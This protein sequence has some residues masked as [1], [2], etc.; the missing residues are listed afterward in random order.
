MSA[1]AAVAAAAPP[2]AAPRNLALTAFV[3]FV[4]LT[5]GF[6]AWML[7]RQYMN[8]G[9]LWTWSTVLT[10]LDAEQGGFNRFVL[11]YPQAQYYVLT[12][13]ALVPGAKSLL[14]P[15]AVAALVAAALL[16]HFTLGLLRAGLPLARALPIVALVAL[17]PALIWAV[18]NG[19]AEIYGIVLYYVLA[20]AIVGMRY[21]H[22]LRA[23]LVLA[24]VLLGFFLTDARS[25]YLALAL[26]PVLPLAL[27]PHL[28]RRGY[29]SPLAIIYTPLLCMIGIWLALNWVYTRDPL[30]FLQDP[31]SPFLGAR[32][33]LEH[34]PWRATF[35]GGVGGPL[36]AAVALMALCFPLLLAA[37]VRTR[38]HSRLFEAIAVLV[39]TPVI[40]TALA[41]AAEFT[42]SPADILVFVLGGVM[43]LLT[44]GLLHYLRHGLV[45][46]LLVAGNLGSLALFAWYPAAGMASWTAALAGRIERPALAG[47]L[48]LGIWAQ[49]AAPIMLDEA[50]GY[51]VIAAR[52][53]ATQLDLTFTNGFKAGVNSG[54]PKSRF[55]AVPDPATQ[56]GRADQLNRRFPRLYEEGLPGYARVYDH[57][58]WRVYARFNAPVPVPASPSRQHL[59]G[60]S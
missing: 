25:L 38:R 5:A 55:I 36:L 30:H 10:S 48:A 57:E 52:G 21:A 37:L 40:A 12:L 27:P 60:V 51:A 20:L 45:L 58:G 1:P 22:S 34:M 44:A 29:L 11:L 28:L 9:T 18:S 54:K 17:N 47:D 8:D 49:Q 16:T 39:V 42:Q 4:A 50:S 3:A 31:A 15:Y 46:A 13:L 33:S 41:T 35:G 53:S 23:H 14:L 6:T 24:L 32:L 19:G 59:A 43:A 2:L 26:L 7:S 56:R